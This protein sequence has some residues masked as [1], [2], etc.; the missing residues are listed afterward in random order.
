MSTTIALVTGANK[1][2]GRET[3][4][5]LAGLGWRVFLAARDSTRGE[6]AVQELGA[7]NVEFLPLDVTSDASVIA[8]ADLV[9]ERAG[10]LDVLINNAGIGAPP[11]HP[12]DTTADEVRDVLD[13]NVLGAVRV[14]NAFLP[15]LRKAGNPRIVMVS[16]GMGS[17]A[18]TRDPRFAGMVPP[19]LA[20]PASKAA[21]NMV[22]VQY[23]AGLDGIRVNAVDPGY[24]ATDMTDNAGVQTVEEGTDAI[25][26]LATVEA[27][28]PTGGFFD[29]TG[30]VPW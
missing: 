23:A 21:L 14:T 1:G 3:V 27:D 20:Y 13:V 18:V 8:A 2:L 29:R 26:R 15:L 25:I 5:R 19:M 6:A 16:S 9:R 12:E 4:R 22:T 10:R 11:T 17:I 28:G 7:D 30:D 24:T